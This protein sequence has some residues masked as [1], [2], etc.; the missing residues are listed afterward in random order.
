MSRVELPCAIILVTFEVIDKGPIKM[1]KSFHVYS[2][3]LRLILI[4]AVIPID[5]DYYQ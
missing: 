4:V 2:N 3:S 5:N 1:R